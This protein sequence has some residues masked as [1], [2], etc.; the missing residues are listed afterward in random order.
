M[1]VWQAHKGKVRSLAFSPDG[2][3]LATA[4]GTNGKIVVW[5]VDG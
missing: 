2:Q 5:D 4:T 3:L 1:F